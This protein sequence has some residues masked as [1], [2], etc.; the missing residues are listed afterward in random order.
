ME[1]ESQLQKVPNFRDV[2]KTVNQFLNKRFELITHN[3]D[4]SSL[5]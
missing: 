3:P 2:G 5:C 4:A 1:P